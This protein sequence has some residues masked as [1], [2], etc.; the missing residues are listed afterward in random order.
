MDLEGII[1]V[2]IVTGGDHGGGRFRML[3]KILLCF[4][5]KPSIPYN[6]EVA[7]VSHSQDNIDI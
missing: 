2:D 6:Y 4:T 3:L 5:N 1:G 7:N